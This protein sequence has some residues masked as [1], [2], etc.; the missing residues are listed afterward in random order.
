MKLTFDA[1]NSEAIMRLLV[2]KEGFNLDCF[3]SDT[4]MNISNDLD[5]IATVV[6]TLTKH[7]FKFTLSTS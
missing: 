4:T 6:N 7:R 1:N 3:D 2:E 5:D